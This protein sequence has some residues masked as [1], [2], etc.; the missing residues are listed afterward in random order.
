M[1][2][3]RPG[4][5]GFLALAGAAVAPLLLGSTSATAPAAVSECREPSARSAAPEPVADFADLDRNQRVLAG[6]V[7]KRYR[8]ALEAVEPV[9]SAAY[10]AAHEFRLDPLLILAVIAI[11]S[12]FNPIAESVVGAQ[13]LMQVMPR[14]HRDKLAEHGDGQNLLDPATNIYVGAHILHEYVRGTGSLESGL[15]RYNG[16]LSDADARYA[17][18]VMAMRARLREALREGSTA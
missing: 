17:K 16:A 12:R 6:F 18:K 2:F 13:G 10:E 8:V 1:A 4:F 9:V 7:S 5:A 11:E 15:Q 3:F 14:F